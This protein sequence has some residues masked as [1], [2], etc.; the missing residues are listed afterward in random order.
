MQNDDSLF[1]SHKHDEPG[2][3]I[4]I[5]GQKEWLVK[6]ILDRHRHGR[7][8]QYLIEWEGY[9]PEHNQ[10]MPSKEIDDLQA[11]DEFLV[12]NGLQE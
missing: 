6:R 2:P 5:N 1:P 4:T 10:W 9:G 11:L 12:A 8:W 3:V 7:G